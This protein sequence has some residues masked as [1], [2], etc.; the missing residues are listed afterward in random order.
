M[1]L[2]KSSNSSRKKI[3]ADPVAVTGSGRATLRRMTSKTGGY[4]ERGLSVSVG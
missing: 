1:L 3:I 4:R 2:C